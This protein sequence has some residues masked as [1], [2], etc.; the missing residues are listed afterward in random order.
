MDTMV[1]PALDILKETIKEKETESKQIEIYVNEFQSIIDC[2][3]LQ[4]LPRS[5]Q[6]TI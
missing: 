3:D 5:P 4:Y 2:I 1:S 6:G